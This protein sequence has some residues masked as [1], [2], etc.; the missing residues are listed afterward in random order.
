MSLW[1]CVESFRAIKLIPAKWGMTKKV[2][3]RIV[4]ELEVDGMVQ[5]DTQQK[6]QRIPM[7]NHSLPWSSYWNAMS[8]PPATPWTYII[9]QFLLPLLDS[10]N[11]EGQHI[12][13]CPSGGH[14]P[15][16]SYGFWVWQRSRKSL[17]AI[18]NGLAWDARSRYF[19]M[20][21]VISLVAGRGN[22][23]SGW[24]ICFISSCFAGLWLGNWKHWR[25][26]KDG[27][28]SGLG[29]NNTV[30]GLMDAKGWQLMY[31]WMELTVVYCEDTEDGTF[32]L[33]TLSGQ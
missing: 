21:R 12:L 25:D 10:D 31:Y 9:P 33:I 11:T 13:G 30:N 6:K 2:G 27:I 19:I 18:R 4:H 24:R 32:S 3:T 1:M 17:S 29:D 26:N 5:G 28:G 15:V 7:A 16:L 23:E 14:P 20:I 22:I 8:G